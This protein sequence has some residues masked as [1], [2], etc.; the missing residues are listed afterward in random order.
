MA[1]SDKD[2]ARRAHAAETVRQITSSETAAFFTSLLAVLNEAAAAPA[3]AGHHEPER[4]VAEPGL[5]HLGRPAEPSQKES[6][7]EG[8]PADPRSGAQH[9]DGTG[10]VPAEPTVHFD[11]VVTHEAPATSAAAP[12]GASSSA[13]VTTLSI[14]AG[15]PDASA[16][17]GSPHQAAASHGISPGIASAAPATD[18]TAAVSQTTDGVTG[19]LDSSLATVSQGISH[20]ISDVGATINQL[21]SSLSGTINHLTDS[22]SG[23]TSTLVHDAPVTAVVEPLLTDVLGS[24]QD[25]TQD[26]SAHSQDSP[27]HGIPLLDTAGAIPTALLHPLPLHLGFLGQP[28]IDGHEPH[29]AAF[30][31]LAMHHF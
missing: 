9:A 17:Q 15:S 5:H 4:P 13:P 26:T 21:T 2:N 1:I 28:T 18:P 12:A 24:A 25:S 31:T 19:F 11:G 29:D 3:A 7:T 23:L 6:V 14:A 27:S 8:M 10:A 30:S 16:D 22:L 20:V